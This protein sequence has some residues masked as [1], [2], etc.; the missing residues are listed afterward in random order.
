[1]DYHGIEG[2]EWDDGKSA[3]CFRE[4]GFDFMA[5]LPVFGDPGRRVVAD[6]R[7]DYGEPRFVLT[8]RVEGRVFVVVYT[9][10]GRICRLISARKAN[11]REVLDH[12][13]QMHQPC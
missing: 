3:R 6:Q 10:R 8:G 12:E 2:F 1:M 5:I 11:R 9:L 7:W 4:R 13:R